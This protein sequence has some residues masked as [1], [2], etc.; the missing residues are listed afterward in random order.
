MTNRIKAPILA[1][2]AVFAL[3]GCDLLDVDNPNSLVEESIQLEAASNG[4]ANGSLRLVADAVATIWQGPAM[5][6]DELY[7]TGS[8]DAWGS[9][10]RGNIGDP[11]NEFLDSAFPS[12]GQATWMAK[13]AVTII[14]EH[15]ANNAGDASFGL[16]LANA[17][18]YNGIILMVTG[19]IQDDMTFSDK[20]TDGPPVGQANMGGVIDSAISELGLAITQFTAL[21]NTDLATAATALR[22]R[23]HMSRVIWNAINPSATAG[24]ALAFPAALADA[25]A[26]LTAASGADWQ[27][28]LIYGSGKNSCFMCSN[29]NQRGENQLDQSLVENTGPGASGRTGVIVLKDP[30]TGSDDAALVTAVAQWGGNQYGSLT[31]ASARMMRLIIAEDALAGGDAAAFA[32]QINAIRAYDDYGS[33]SDFVSGGA[34]TDVAMLQHTRR[35]NTLWQGLRLQDMYRW[36]LTDPL[37]AAGST[38]LVSPGQMLPIT[39]VEIRANCNLGTS[40]CS[41]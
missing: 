41:G 34:V 19:E 37:W 24:G 36:G 3:S 27:Y 11:L 28:N 40:T 35:V 26:V 2:A 33:A 17:H 10:D 30:V 5:V 4:V 16:D 8:R 14:S 18:L 15:V 6:A 38:T 29:V 21:G 13:N 22:A 32:T 7:W 23:A 1:V 9:L 20:Q 12:L 39:I 25:N 31:L